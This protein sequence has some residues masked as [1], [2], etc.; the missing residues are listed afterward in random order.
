VPFVVFAL[1]GGRVP[2]ALDVMH[3]LA[4]DLG[5]DLAP[6]LA[7]GA[8]RP[9]PDVMQRP[10]RSLDAHLIDRRLLTRSYLWLGPLQAAFVM[11][12]FFGAY[13][14]AGVQGWLDLP[15][16]GLIYQSATAMALSAVVATQI[17]NLFTQRS[18][19]MSLLRVGLG[20][21]RL[22][23]WGILSEL[24]VIALIVYVP[25]LQDV[26]GTAPFPAAG[27]P[28]L[29]LGVPLLPIADEVRKIVMRLRRR[30]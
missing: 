3:I 2:L 22:L 8:E 5:T 14:L 15:S 13:R 30:E 29:L 6:A 10:P 19:R 1:S 20:G 12:A 26:I 21:N 28:W 4:I 25:L 23:W 17:G 24:V 9:E 7:L 11:T 16:Q 18:E 27:W